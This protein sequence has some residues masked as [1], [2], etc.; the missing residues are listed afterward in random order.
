M[1]PTSGRVV[2][3]AAAPDDE[4]Q[5][6][7]P[8]PAWAEQDPAMWWE[9]VKAAT[10]KIRAKAGFLLREIAA[11][12]ISY[13]M[14]GLVVIDRDQRVLR[15]AIIW[16]DSRAVEIGARAFQALGP[17]TCRECLLNSPGNFTASKLKWV[18]EHEP[19]VFPLIDKM[20]LPGDYIALK[21]TGEACTTPGGL[22]EGILWDYRQQ[23]VAAEVLEYYAIPRAMIPRIVPTFAFQ[24]S[25][26]RR[27]AEELGLAPG[28]PVTYRAGDQSN[29]AWALNV[30]EPGEVAATAGTSGVI[31]GIQNAPQPDP[32][33]R[34]NVF[35]H[36]NHTPARP[37]YGAL[38]C[39]NGAGILNRW[40]K[41]YLTSLSYE[42]INALAAQAPVGAD[43]LICLPYGNGAERTLDNR[44]IGASL[45]G[46]NL[47]IHTN[48]HIL[49]AAQEGVAF[50]M[51]YGLE[52]MRSMGIAPAI[53]RAGYTNM[54][55]S[56]VF[57]ETF[58]NVTATSVE[59]FDTDG[60]QGAARGAGVGAGVYA[61]PDESFVGLRHMR[62]IAPD[63]SAPE[64]YR[65]AYK[66]WH[67]QLNINLGKR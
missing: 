44:D 25:L 64:Q 16:C 60:A 18:S 17:A 58:A 39:V 1:E 55:L 31:Y 6:S 27:A 26:T 66:R 10:A 4:M 40:V 14:H 28:I 51:H 62:T 50:A 43:G 65:A 7:A 22:S 34:V 15:P 29:N 56:P 3:F 11:I 42:G 59:L 30:R 41:Q 8:S 45:H 19:E 21:M 63:H 49:R 67:T 54:F 20:L 47:K 24:G 52:I 36:V 2:A 5:I 57:A 33:S 53:I 35:L 9:Q 46:L 38:L 23:D 13:Q 12:G 61:N 37:R 32:L 48:A